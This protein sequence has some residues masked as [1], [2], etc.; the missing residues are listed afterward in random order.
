[1]PVR[2]HSSDIRDI[3][4]ESNTRNAPEYFLDNCLSEL[5]LI[6]KQHLAIKKPMNWRQA[7]LRLP[8]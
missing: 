2:W 7:S 3:T 5:K 6:L 1:V 4:L 8:E